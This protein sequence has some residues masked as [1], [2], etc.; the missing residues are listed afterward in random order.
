MPPFIL[1]FPAVVLG[2]F[3]GGW[4]VGTAFVLFTGFLAWFVVL[5]PP[6]SW[7]LNAPQA[8]VL[9][10]YV[11]ANSLIVFA[12]GQLNVAL[13][14]LRV[15]R[16]RLRL[17]LQTAQ[18]GAWEFDPPA[19]VFW[20]RSYFELVGISPGSAQPSLPLFMS[21][22]HPSDRDK[23]QV[24]PTQA[25]A[26]QAQDGQ[27]YRVLKGDGSTIWVRN[28]IQPDSYG[29]SRLFGVT[30]DITKDK[31]RE[32][33]IRALMLEVAHRV[34][35]Q[36]A[37]ILSMARAT[38]QPTDT[39]PSYRERLEGRIGAMAHAYDLLL[40]SD[41]EGAELGKLVRQKLDPFGVQ[42][43]SSGPKVTLPPA[44]VQAMAL[45]LHEL[46][47]NALAHGA[48]ARS[49]GHV[50]VHWDVMEG[51]GSTRLRFVWDEEFGLLLPPT[52][53]EGFGTRALRKLVPTAMGGDSELKRT[54]T[55]LTWVLTSTLKPQGN[56]SAAH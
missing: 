13:H 26:G 21:L 1:F 49:K 55:G 18:L 12:V 34:K 23:V 40:A 2:T 5:D 54:N 48:L 29:T 37:V 30:Q 28:R 11:A 38:E 7:R 19:E 41:W 25:A 35:N 17:A 45:A 51:D 9:C 33:R 44:A 43:S 47:S 50:E 27:E 56:I 31:E 39:V 14:R 36:L 6:L 4:R 46:T 42:A 15:E 20:D 24:L 53:N 16:Q 3:F 32:E 8:I 52:D 22:I 10:T